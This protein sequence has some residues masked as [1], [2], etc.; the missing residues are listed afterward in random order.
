MSLKCGQVNCVKV[1]EHHIIPQAFGGKNAHTILLCAT[2][3]DLVHREQSR[4]KGGLKKP[5]IVPPPLQDFIGKLASFAVQAEISQ[6]PN[7]D[8]VKTIMVKVTQ[9]ELNVLH[10]RKK[11]AGFS[12]LDDFL[13][14]IIKKITKLTS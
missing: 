12:S 2:C 6:I 13:Y 1:H 7:S 5:S 4:I 8:R 3:H 10:M 14:A 9:Q 11:D